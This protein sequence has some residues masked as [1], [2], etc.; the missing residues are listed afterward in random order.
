MTNMSSIKYSNYVKNELLKID[1]RLA[2]QQQE[3]DCNEFSEDFFKSLMSSD[4]QFVK[5]LWACSN[6]LG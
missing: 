5:T 3:I 4:I 6:D 2:E 1:Q